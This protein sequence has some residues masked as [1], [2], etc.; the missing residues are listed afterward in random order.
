MDDPLCKE[1]HLYVQVI[2]MGLPASEQWLEQR[3][4]REGSR[5][6]SIKELCEKGKL[7]WDTMQKQYYPVRDELN[8]VN[9]IFMR[10]QRMIIPA[11]LRKL[12]LSK[13]HSGN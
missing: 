11:P 13:L 7:P 1:V 9:G 6:L 4:T 2:V 12:M 3:T 10:G 5:A 8:V